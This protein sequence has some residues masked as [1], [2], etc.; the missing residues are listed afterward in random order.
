M[1][2]AW[3]KKKPEKVSLV[4]N[5]VY[6]ERKVTGNMI[7]QLSSHSLTCDVTNHLATQPS[8]GLT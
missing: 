1:W 6:L 4:N 8:A 5:R 3:P 2:V 7:F